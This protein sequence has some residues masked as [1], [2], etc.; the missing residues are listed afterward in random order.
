MMFDDRIPDSLWLHR[1]REAELPVSTGR[2]GPYELVSE[3]DRGGQGV[4]FKARQPGTSRPVALKRL[5]GGSFATRAARARFEREIEAICSL[6]HPNIVTVFGVETIDGAPVLAMEWIDGRPLDEWARGADGLGRSRQTLL[7]AFLL[8]CEAVRHAHQRGVIHRDLKPTNILVTS[9]DCPHVLD[10]GLARAIDTDDSGAGRLTM[11]AELVGTPAYASPEQ[12]GLAG[13]DIDSRTDVYSLGAILY[14]LICRR[15]PHNTSRGLP[16]LLESIRNDDPPPPSTISA[17]IDR[18]LDTIALKALSRDREQ[19]YQSVDALSADL[20]RY[21]AGEPVAA[22][23]PSLGYQLQKMIRRHRTTFSLTLVVLLLIISFGVTSAA[24]AWKLNRERS[25]AIAARENESDARAAAEEVSDFLRRMLA[26]ARPQVAQGEEVTVNQIVDKAVG[27]ME[28]A[29]ESRP[30]VEAVVRMTLGETLYGL[31]RY[32]EAQ[33]QLERSLDLFRQLDGL[34]GRDAAWAMLHLGHVRRSQ[35]QFD[36]AIKLYRD[37]V[38]TYRRLPAESLRLAAA[39]RSLATASMEQN[40][41]AAAQEYLHE[42]QAIWAAHPQAGNEDA[43]QG[44]IHLAALSFHRG[45]YGEAEEWLR[46]ALAQAR[47]ALGDRHELT[48]VI[49]S[50]LA[51]ALKKQDRA[52]EARPYAEECLSTARLVF[53]EAHPHT[54]QAKA[55]MAPLLQSLAQH[56]QA[57]ALYRD[58]HEHFASRNQLDQ[59]TAISNASNLASL[60]LE[61]KRFVEAAEVLRAA[62]A[63]SKAAFGERHPGTAI[64][65]G[66]LGTAIHEAS[67]GEADAEARQLLTEALSI[68]EASL[69]PDH[70]H[71]VKTREILMK[72]TREMKLPDAGYR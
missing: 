31:G 17:G 55:N 26:A 64:A 33:A 15:T 11:T 46:P 56:S 14:L 32:P 27:R 53:G 68:F 25:A 20:R 47:S 67:S 4:V 35:N 5:I 60:L 39:L 61:Q 58:L 1:L 52:I 34:D 2:I 71:V 65:M 24:L 21:L 69:P 23:P 54:V 30:G 70:P 29:F 66:L 49:L 37:A 43:I 6:S 22:H 62:L 19:R 42:A 59:P 9:D 45:K 13:A 18:D 63:R 51:I 50:N 72:L 44:S 8:V 28:G 40:N 38:D 36:D 41:L 10:F 57:E 48:I 7:S 12:I 3:V 16:A